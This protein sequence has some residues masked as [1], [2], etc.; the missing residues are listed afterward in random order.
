[1]R[2]DSALT[3]LTASALVDGYRAQRYSPVE[4][5]EACLAVVDARD[6]ALNAFLVVAR[7][8]ALAAAR[9]S[10][11]RWRAGAPLGPLDGVPYTAKDQYAS[12]GWPTRSGSL[13]T[14][15]AP[16]G[17]DAP[18]VARLREAGAILL[19]KTTMCEFGWK[20]VTDSPLGGVSR[21]PWNPERTSGGSSGGAAIAAATGMGV[22]HVGSDGAGSIRIPAAYCGVFG[23]KPTFGRVPAYPPGRLALGHTGPITRS[24]EDAALA[25]N[26]LT[27]PD[28]RDALA[29]PC[30][31]IDH[32]DGLEDGVRG[33]RIAWCPTLCGA[34]PDADVLRVTIAAV[35]TLESL[36]AIV[37]E[38]DSPI[39]TPR[40]WFERLWS[41]SMAQI[42]R[43]IP[44]EKRVL[45]DPGFATVARAGLA[46]SANDLLD[47]VSARL[48][49]GTT[50]SLFH[51][52]YDLLVTPQMPTTAF[53]A[54]VD[55]PA[56]RGMSS[57]LD[58]SPYTIA[59]NATQQPAASVP[60]GFG[61]DAMPVGLQV[62]GARHDEVRVLRACRA[63]EG[64]VP[65]AALP[66]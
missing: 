25:M 45:C 35:R 46:L 4:V 17:D 15:D 51:Q 54:G 49:D 38:V 7:E 40:P 10:E 47:A 50:M 66:G 53:E 3:R 52:R 20:G 39:D 9:E 31:P 58:W 61:D 8:S 42:W 5:V 30:A 41:A 44:D 56:G 60:C 37:D 12:A 24:V 43:R 64:A 29:L 55:V 33:L 57:W 32:R 1:M 13:T 48:A 2:P 16:A 14:S 65:F 59:F 26:A 21:N 28:A 23:L 36:G 18:P 6:P 11:R 22:I 19:G 34:R 27:R 63:F 62:V